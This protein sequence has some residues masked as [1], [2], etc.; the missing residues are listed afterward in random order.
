MIRHAALGCVYLFRVANCDAFPRAN[1]SRAASRGHSFSRVWN[2][3][4]SLQS[5]LNLAIATQLQAAQTN[6]KQND[7]EATKNRCRLLPLCGGKLLLQLD[8]LGEGA[9]Q[10]S[11]RQ[12]LLLE[13][14]RLKLI[15]LLHFQSIAQ[16]STCESELRTMLSDK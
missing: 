8:A 7:N 12:L 13:R 15:E 11:V 5:Q 3:I 2:I 4:G 10:F 16:A 9:V 6:H 1:E 14:P